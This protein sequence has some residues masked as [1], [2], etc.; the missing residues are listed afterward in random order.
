MKNPN[1]IPYEIIVRATN[2]EPE[3]V[4]EVYGI[5][6]S[7]SELLLLKADTSTKTQR[8]TS[9]GGLSLPCSSSALMNRKQKIE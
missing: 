8:T 5:T 2:R 6:A 3:A 9:S 1:L 4:D 7:E